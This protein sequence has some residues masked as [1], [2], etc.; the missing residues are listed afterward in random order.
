MMHST[1][2]AIAAIARLTHGSPLLS[3]QT[4][5]TG[6]TCW[7]Q[8]PESDELQWQPCFGA[9]TCSRLKVP[10][11]YTNPSVGTATIAYIRQAAQNDSESAE[12][13]L[14]NPG[15]PGESGVGAVLNLG[16]QLAQVMP[17][18]NLIGFD[19]RG[20]NNS[21]PALSCFGDD[22]ES[23][24]IEKEYSSKFIRT[25]DGKNEN[26]LRYQ[27]EAATAFGK[28]C[29]KFNENTDAKYANTVAVAQ[30]MAN[31]IEKAAKLKG[32]DPKEAKLNYYGVSYG[33]VLGSVYASLFPTR[34]GRFV[35]D[36]VADALEYY[37]GTYASNVRDVDQVMGDF[38]K[39]CNA[40]GPDKCALW[41]DTP[42]A[43]S[44]RARAIVESVRKDPIP[45]VDT[46]VVQYPTVIRYEEVMQLV[47]TAMYSP[48]ENWPIIAQILADVEGR[49][50]N[51]AAQRLSLVPITM[52]GPPALVGGLDAVRRK[53]NNFDTFEKW[54][55]HLERM[56]EESEWGADAWASLGLAVKDLEITPPISQQFNDTSFNV[57]TNAPILF[58][59]NTHDPATPIHGAR[60]MHSLFPGSGL[61]VQEAPGHVAS[62]SAVSTCTLGLI[63]QFYATGQLPPA[64]TTCTVES[65]PFMSGGM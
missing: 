13:V 6:A 2:F 3:R 61:L 19:P 65:V 11:D 32:K 43:I 62:L 1:L 36:G 28:W 44:K 60:K 29:T 52:L 24:R 40:A 38:F 56:T 57:Q 12:D 54:T 14:I 23:R 47:F 53:Q 45:V 58:V 42:D 18:Y 35:L 27:F 30:D 37:T 63:G 50:G 10:L 25:V 7:D 55:A 39:F 20:I 17:Q 16:A 46:A 26:S 22:E 4:N 41:A 51:S 9:Y 8:I 31:Y 15:G 5:T 21:G 59:S 34:L 48:L 64:N 49:N 33:T